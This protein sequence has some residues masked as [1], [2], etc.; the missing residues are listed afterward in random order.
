MTQ[1]NGKTFHAPGSEEQILV[2]CLY[3]P[4][5]STQLLQSLSKFQ[6]NFHRT[7]TNNPKMCMEL[8]KTPN[9]QTTLKKKS[10]AGDITIL[11]FKLYYK[12]ELTKTV[13]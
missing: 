9:S 4:N 10:K 11:D 2:K 3:Y 13:W 12:A 5:Q 1:S 7:R 6:S 8:Q